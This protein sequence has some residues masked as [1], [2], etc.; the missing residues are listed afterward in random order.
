MGTRSL[1]RDGSAKYRLWQVYAERGTMAPIPPVPC[2][3][4][5]KFMLPRVLLCQDL[6]QDQDQLR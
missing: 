6:D 3:I 5:G 2:P 4:G 1:R